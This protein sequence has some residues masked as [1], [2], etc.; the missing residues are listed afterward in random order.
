L[1][2]MAWLR[3]WHGYR[4]GMAW[5]GMAWQR[6]LLRAPPAFLPRACPLHRATAGPITKVAIHVLSWYRPVDG[7]IISSPPA[8]ARVFA[9]RRRIRRC[10]AALLPPRPDTSSSGLPRH[11]GSA[12][13]AYQLIRFWRTWHPVQLCRTP[14]ATLTISV[15]LSRSHESAPVRLPHAALRN[16]IRCW[17]RRLAVPPRAGGAELPRT[18]RPPERVAVFEPCETKKCNS[19]VPAA[20]GVPCR[21]L[22]S[23]AT[24]AA[25][26]TNCQ[27]LP[28]I[29]R[30]CQ[31]CFALHLW[32]VA[33]AAVLPGNEA[34][35]IGPIWSGLW[36]HCMQ[37]LSKLW[38]AEL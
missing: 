10:R 27:A 37:G 20:Q 31:A 4:H 32:G 38:I 36:F 26:A 18:P 25:A 9:R 19:S 16:G 8:S 23:C 21:D 34:Q 14:I 22:G 11:A 5:H 7:S 3:A 24:T 15:H 2:S 29:A 1:V 30:H 12:M 6:R 33:S 17:P 35:V 13:K 28:G